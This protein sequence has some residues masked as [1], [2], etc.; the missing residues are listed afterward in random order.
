MRSQIEY[1]KIESLRGYERNA[2][3]HSA[4][5]IEQICRSIREFG[6]TNP[7]LIDS[8]G[9][10]IAG[11]GRLIAAQKLGMNELPCIRLGHLCS[12]QVRALV[13]ADNRIAE[14]SGWD[15]ELVKSEIKDLVANSYAADLTAFDPEE[16]LR[17]AAGNVQRVKDVPVQKPPAVAWVLIECPIAEFG[18][19]QAVLDGL[20]DCAETYTTFTDELKD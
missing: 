14:G 4:K 13:L 12:N 15:I 8:G 3:T 9:V 19:V 18:K 10:I 16:L 20:P 5:Q 6:F 17:E 1:V 7:L 2:R 11:H